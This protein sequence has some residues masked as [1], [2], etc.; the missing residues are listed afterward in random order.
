MACDLTAVSL[1][2]IGSV[3]GGDGIWRSDDLDGSEG[4]IYV[5]VGQVTETSLSQ[6]ISESGAPPPPFTANNPNPDTEYVPRVKGVAG[7]SMNSA[8]GTAKRGE[9]DVDVRVQ[10]VNTTGD[11][12]VAGTLRYAVARPASTRTVVVFDTSG[13]HIMGSTITAQNGNKTF[14]FQTAPSPGYY[15]RGSRLW[16]SAPDTLWWHLGITQGGPFIDNALDSIAVN[17]NGT[18]NFAF[19]NCH[20]WAGED[21]PWDINNG[22]DTATIYNCMISHGLGPVARSSIMNAEPMTF[23]RNAFIHCGQRIPLIDDPKMDMVNN[24]IANLGSGF[25]TQLRKNMTGNLEQN[26]WMEGPDTGSNNDAVRLEDTLDSSNQIYYDNDENRYIG[27]IDPENVEAGATPT[28]LSSP[29]TAARADGTVVTD[30]SGWTDEE[31]VENL[32]HN[33]G[34]RPGDPL[35][36]LT[37][38]KAEA[39]AMESGVGDQGGWEGNSWTKGYESLT[40]TPADNLED[41]ATF[42]SENYTSG[43]DYSI[44]D[45]DPDGDG[46]AII[47]NFTVDTYNGIKHWT[48]IDEWLNQ[49]NDAV[50]NSG[51]ET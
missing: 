20:A 18:S 43:T 49:K 7:H 3:A 4:G 11:G 9:S 39:A 31:V 33:C 26:C 41:L 51:W 16:M 14:A 1:N 10:V 24:L 28:R 25:N 48:A 36:Y 29:L 32:L 5:A 42:L 21:G 12:S 50:M 38:L 35:A 19:I 22:P 46:L 15:L 2:A 44:V 27:N 30:M 40:T 23:A 13:W 34:A 6:S 47:Y 8:F 37:D 45:A 17:D